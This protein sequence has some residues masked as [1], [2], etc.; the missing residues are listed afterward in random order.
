M[1]TLLTRAYQLAVDR[2]GTMEQIAYKLFNMSA[3]WPTVLLF[4][5][6][7]TLFLPL[8]ASRVLA[9]ILALAISVGLLVHFKRNLNYWTERFIDSRFF[10][11]LGAPEGLEY[12]LREAFI[13]GFFSC[14]CVAS[15]VAMIAIPLA[16]ISH[17]RTSIATQARIEGRNMTPPML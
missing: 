6:G 17:V 4:I 10:P 5:Y 16:S 11:D 8:T 3:H 9:F 12:L 14:F 1:N 15:A 7:M 2:Q 13:F